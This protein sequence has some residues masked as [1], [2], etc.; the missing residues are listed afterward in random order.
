MQIIVFLW[1]AHGNVSNQVSVTLLSIPRTWL[2]RGTSCCEVFPSL[3]STKKQLVASCNFNFWSTHNVAS[4]LTSWLL[5]H[6]LLK[7]LLQDEW[8]MQRN[9]RFLL[10]VRPMLLEAVSI[11][12][13]KLFHQVQLAY[14]GTAFHNEDTMSTDPSTACGHFNIHGAA[15]CSLQQPSV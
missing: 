6:E 3:I 12:L 5:R 4:I 13:Y 14:L 1:A 10:Q 9:A 7:W 11:C 8:C 2:P 15:K